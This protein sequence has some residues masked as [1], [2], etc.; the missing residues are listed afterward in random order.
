MDNNNNNVKTLMNKRETDWFRGIAA[1]MVVLSHYGHWWNILTPTQG[2]VETFRFALTKLGVYGVDIFFLFSGYAMIKSLGDRKMSWQFVWKRI[3]NVYIPYFLIILAIELYA[4][5]LTSLHDL[6]IVACGYKYW[7]MM[8]LFLFYIGFIVIYALIRIKWL[9]TVIFCIFTYIMSYTLYK[10]GMQSFWYVSNI[11]FAIGIIAGEYEETFKKIIDKIWIYM[12][13]V[14]SIG[15]A[16]ATKWGL[17]GGVNWGGNP[18]DYQIWVQ[19]GATVVWTLLILILAS[20][21]HINEVIFAF[22]GKN[23]LYLYLTHV[24]VAMQCINFPK[25]ESMSV[26]FIISPVCIIAVA[27][28]C[29]L[30]IS[31]MW[32]LLSMLASLI[33][34]N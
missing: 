31:C 21:C 3:K 15:M 26:R 14:L 1:L 34:K 8:V 25:I 23:S 5:A 2:N 16:F 13:I 12:L 27:I 9:R 11:A 20:K 30:I 24:F 7:Y 6:W 29:N 22:L 33:K 28:L 32:R 4:G 19:I 18:A 17:D 10:K